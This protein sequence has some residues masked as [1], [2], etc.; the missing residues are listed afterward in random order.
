VAPRA[1]DE[2]AVA[3]SIRFGAPRHCPSHDPR[4]AH[5]DPAVASPTPASLTSRVPARRRR[6]THTRWASP[7]DARSILPERWQW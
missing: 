7:P 6:H 2:P 5:A 3:R 4:V 1:L